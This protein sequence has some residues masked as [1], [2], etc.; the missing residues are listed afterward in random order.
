MKNNYLIKTMTR[1]QLDMAVDWAAQEGWN[2]G[3]YD[4][5]SFYT[6]DPDG[7]FMGFLDDKPIACV[8]AVAYNQD[9]GFVGFYIVKPKYR[10][11]GYG[12]KIWQHAI[13]YLTTQ[14]IGLDGVIEQQENYKKSGFKLAYSNIRH[15]GKS[16]KIK[17]ISKN[18]VKLNKINF[19]ELLSYDDQF[20]P[21]SRPQFLKPWIKQPESTV[22]GYIKQ[23]KLAGYGM[24]RKCRQGY[25]IGPL[26]ADSKIIAKKLLAA[27]INSLDKNQP[28]YLDVPE[29]NQQA[30]AL[31]KKFKMKKVFGTARMYTQNEPKLPINQIFGVTTFELG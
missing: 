10:G 15:E 16:T 25:K 4:A 13:N 8:S 12:Y 21:V 3:L 9:F 28:F 2:P 22:L 6:T 23:D 18:I 31:A 26:F 1:D 20:F 19:Q 27:L 29:P 11:H 7:F 14:N 30:V 24:I 5:D 17:S